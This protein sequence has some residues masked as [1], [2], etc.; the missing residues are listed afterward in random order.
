[1]NQI[2]W[3]WVE[4]EIF[5]V[6]Q[7]VKNPP[8]ME[9]QV[10]SLG[11][12]DSLEVGVAT[13]SCILAWE[14]PWTEEPGGLQ[15]MGSWVRHD[16]SNWAYTCFLKCFKIIFPLYLYIIFI[17]SF[18]YTVEHAEYSLPNQGWNL[19]SLQWKHRVLTTGPPG[20]SPN[21]IFF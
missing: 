8:A 7:S 4:T 2:L 17:I 11:R 13:H 21:S 3:E 12:K 5:P 20:K 19:C 6:A 18:S 9:T 16:W 1:M 14:I 15:S 10:Q